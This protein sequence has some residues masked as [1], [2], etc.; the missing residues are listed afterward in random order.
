MNQWTKRTA[1]VLMAG[2]VVVTGL[3]GCGSKAVDNNEVVATVNGEDI[4][5]GVANFSARMN[6]ASVE[7]YYESMM[8][9]S[10]GSEMWTSE[11]SEGMTY[12]DSVK[13]S[14]MESLQSLYLIRQHAE[15]YGVELTEEEQKAIE[16]AV[17]AFEED[18]ASE[19]KELISGEEVYVKEFLELMTIEQKMREPMQ[20]GYDANVSDEEAAQK[21]MSY[22]YFSFNTTDADG[23]SVEMTDDEK[24]ELK[25]KAENF[26]AALKNDPTMTMDALSAEYEVEVSTATFDAEST[27]PNADLIAAVDAFAAEG[28]VTD[29]IETENGYYVGQL[30]SLFDEEATATEKASIIEERK[31]TQYTELLESWKEEAEVTVNDEVWEKV[32]FATVGVSYKESSEEYDDTAE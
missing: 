23:N 3:T 7:Y 11:V 22:V 15:E 21:K 1:V 12:E 27:V 26:V 28:E 30:T 5:Y 10:V 6:Q 29:V 19:D 4:S 24:A 8:G 20:D 18:N 16:E 9:T 14:I 25:T 31:N 2:S 13:E 32:D 17:T